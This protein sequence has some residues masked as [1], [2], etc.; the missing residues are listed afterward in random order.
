MLASLQCT[1]TGS[2]VVIRIPSASK[3]DLHQAIFQFRFC[4][5]MID[6]NLDGNLT[7]EMAIGSFDAEVSH[8]IP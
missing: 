3:V 8:P 6:G 7:P 5:F 4:V 2:M 1:L